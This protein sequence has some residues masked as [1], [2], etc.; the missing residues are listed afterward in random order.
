MRVGASSVERRVDEILWD[1]GGGGLEDE[2]A[3][4]GVDA[5]EVAGGEIGAAAAADEGGEAELAG[6]Q[7]GVAERAAVLAADGT[8][9]ELLERDGGG[10]G[11]RGEH[12]DRVGGWGIGE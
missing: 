7:G 10:G 9:A 12:D 8:N 4:L 5:G 3:G 11:E 1:L 2:A 6:H